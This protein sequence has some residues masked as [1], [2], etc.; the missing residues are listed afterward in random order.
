M[1]FLKVGTSAIAE[2]AAMLGSL[3]LGRLLA[4][5]FPSQPKLFGGQPISELASALAITFASSLFGTI[6]DGSL[7]VATQQLLDPIM[8]PG[9]PEWYSKL[10]K[11][12]W[13][14]PG[15]LF[16][17]M[18]LLIVKPTQTAAISRV[19]EVAGE[20]FPWLPLGAFCSHLALGDA[21][22]K[23]FFGMQCTGKGAAVI[24]IFYGVLLASMRFFFKADRLA[25]KLLF[26]SFGWITVATSLNW[27]IFF[28]NKKK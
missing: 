3:K 20:K 27:S 12:W 24:S 8:T 1:L 23:V 14:P 6:A 11:P 2:A 10:E 16:P 5:K 15:W 25:G 22:N 19:L 9:D 28:L 21:W 7:S 26:P 18:W 4:E 17:I 13:N